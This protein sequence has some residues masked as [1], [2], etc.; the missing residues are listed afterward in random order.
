MMCIR[1]Y[2][3]VFGLRL[4]LYIPA[5][6][7]CVLNQ[8]DAVCDF[9]PCYF[10]NYLSCW[11]C[12][13]VRK[14]VVIFK[15]CIAF[16]KLMWCS[17]RFDVSFYQLF[18]WRCGLSGGTLAISGLFFEQRIPEKW[19]YSQT[20]VKPF[21]ISFHAIFWIVLLTLAMP[22]LSRYIVIVDLFFE[23][24]ISEGWHRVPTKCDAFFDFISFHFVNC[25]VGDAACQKVRCHVRI[26]LLRKLVLWDGIPC[27]T[28]PM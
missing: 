18:L 12:R 24:H 13:T 25:F 2:V 20:N 10:V 23:K 26:F 6:W 11:W 3:I 8:L 17:F 15:N 14:Y 7:H 27:W 19:R 9:I 28:D 4:E 22:P 21:S 5:R 1:R 16:L